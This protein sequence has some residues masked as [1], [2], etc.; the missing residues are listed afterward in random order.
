MH[1]LIACFILQHSVNRAVG[2]KA[3]GGNFALG[4]GLCYG[5]FVLALSDVGTVCVAALADVG[6]KLGEGWNKLV[7]REE[8]KSCE[9]Y[10]RKAGSIG[11]QSGIGGILDVKNLDVARGVSAAC[12]FLADV[13]GLL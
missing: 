5:T 1:F 11:K 8:I 4:G 3:G 12:G 6:N 13:A 9:I 2:L 7:E 10:Q